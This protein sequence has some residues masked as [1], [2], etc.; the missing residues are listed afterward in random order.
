MNKRI[1]AKNPMR[2]SVAGREKPVDMPRNGTGDL[3][4]MKAY[5]LYERR[6]RIDGYDLEDWLK[7]EA[8]ISG[9]IE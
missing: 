6:G 7:A 2:K 3:I 9:A 1:S 4:A 8:I 5:E